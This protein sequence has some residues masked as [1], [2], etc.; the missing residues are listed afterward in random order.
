MPNRITLIWAILLQIVLPSCTNQHAQI[1]D[2]ISQTSLGVPGVHGGV[3]A[4][5]EP[6]AT[7]A[8]IRILKQ[9]GNAIDAAAAVAFA[10]N[11]V[12]PHSSGIGGGGFMMIFLAEP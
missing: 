12:E 6:R 2:T 1:Q 11:V 5:S 9:G 3:V 8:G 10:L 4:T 7:K